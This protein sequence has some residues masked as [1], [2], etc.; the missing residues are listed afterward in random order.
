MSKQIIFFLFYTAVI[1]TVSCKGKSS[2]PDNDFDVSV[3][4]PQLKEIKPVVLFDEAHKNHHNITTTYKPFANLIT[5]D[6]CIVKA[7]DKIITPEVLAGAGIF[8]IATAM[9]KEDPGAIPPFTAQ[10]I[11]AVEAWVNNGGGLLLITEHYPFGLAMAPLLGRFGVQVHNGYTEDTLLNNKEVMDALLFEKAKGNLN[12]THPILNKVERINTFTGSSV[13]ADSTWT[14]L[15]TFSPNAQ[16]FNV[17]VDVKKDGDDI[18]TSVE[19]ADF[20][21][22]KGYAEAICKQYGKGRIVVLAES[23]FITAQID[24]N[25]NKFGMNIPNTGNK[26]FTLNLIRWLAGK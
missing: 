12:A 1:F 9:G 24:K 7:S 11:D 19:Y 18:I 25:G 23:A 8:I 15:V 17:K 10:E 6:G 20:Y 14:P 5:N 16:N 2:G 22:A 13:K 21:P 26:Q 4:N 3:T